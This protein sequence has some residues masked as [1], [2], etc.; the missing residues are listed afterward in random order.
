MVLYGSV[1]R[2]PFYSDDIEFYTYLATISPLDI[3]TRADANGLYWRP[4]PQLLYYTLPP[5]AR[6]WHMIVLWTHLLNVA[7]VGALARRLRLNG[8]A[9]LAAMGVMAA[10]P[11]SVQAVAWV[12]S[13]GHVLST[14]MILACVLCVLSSYRTKGVGVVARP[15]LAEGSFTATNQQDVGVVARPTL[16]E[17]IKEEDEREGRGKP[18]PLHKKTPFPPLWGKGWG[19][20][21]VLFGCLAP[22]THENGILAAPVL[23]LFLLWQAQHTGAW[24]KTFRRGVLL[25][26]PIITVSAAYWLYRA[27]L[28]RSNLVFGGDLVERVVGYLAYF[29]QGL[30]L[31]IQLAMNALEGDPVARIWHGTGVMF[32]LVAVLLLRKRERRLWTLFALIGLWWLGSCMPTVLALPPS[33]NLLYDERVLYVSSPSVALFFGLVVAAL[34]GRLRVLVSLVL[35]TTMAAI[36]TIYLTLFGLMG[37]AWNETFVLVRSLPTET[38]GLVINFP[39][40]MERSETLLPQMRPNAMMMQIEFTMRDVLWTN[41]RQEFPNWRGVAQV[42]ALQ[43]DTFPFALDVWQ[44]YIGYGDFMDSTTLGAAIQD[45]DALIELSA[46]GSYS[47]HLRGV[48]VTA[49]DAPLAVFGAVALHEVT[50]EGDL[51]SL[52]WEKRGTLEQPLVAFVHR[53]CDGEIAAQS[54]VPPLH[55]SYSL[56]QWQVG[57]TWR[58]N[59][60]LVAPPT[61]TTLRV[62]LYN[63]NDG[64]PVLTDT[65][66]AFVL[67][68]SR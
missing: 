7:L 67:V 26:V 12:L 54:D 51:V 14:T 59:R 38:R 19:G 37:G 32:L 20:G 17:G 33:Y 10:F 3:F 22:F 21:S 1:V 50:L 31:P 64:Q 49:S 18:S 5:H 27:S 55:P 29:A 34:W 25:L 53:L 61:C 68:E 9:M 42:E 6:L 48:R 41:T 13:W 36:A 43:D 11:F 16:A 30:S 28:V 40:F 8:W 4:I 52:T 44:H 58:E 15:T 66:E 39:R 47:A 23:A 46:N 35:I 63:A 57:E 65:G 56:Q 2:L 45:R 62:G 60:V 24:R